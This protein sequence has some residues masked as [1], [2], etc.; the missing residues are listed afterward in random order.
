MKLLIERVPADLRG[1]LAEQ[2]Y[3]QQALRLALTCSD[4]PRVRESAGELWE[5]AG[6]VMAAIGSVRLLSGT[7][8][9]WLDCART[10]AM[11]GLAA[12]TGADLLDHA[13]LALSNGEHE[14]FAAWLR[15][16]LGLPAPPQSALP[17]RPVPAPAAPALPSSPV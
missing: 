17:E 13:E 2:R 9:D 15:Q 8:A 4:L 1:G 10:A 6:N 11:Q 14:D 5:V 16:L 12:A 3:F 7:A